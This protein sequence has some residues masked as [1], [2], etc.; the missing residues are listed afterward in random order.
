MGNSTAKA[1][2]FDS[3][4]GGLGRL[5]FRVGGLEG[6]GEREGWGGWVFRIKIEA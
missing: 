4:S 3:R 1:S 6:W 2:D 5:G